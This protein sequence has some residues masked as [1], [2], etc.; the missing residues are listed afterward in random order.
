MR[1]SVEIYDM[2]TREAEVVWQTEDLV[3][4][5]NWSRDGEFL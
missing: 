3:E 1:S 5:P 2:A 4:A